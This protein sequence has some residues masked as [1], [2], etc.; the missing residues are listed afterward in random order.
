MSNRARPTWPEGAA[1]GATSRTAPPG[2]DGNGQSTAP[3]DPASNGRP[4]P[5]AN[6]ASGGK[7]PV[8]G[9]KGVAAPGT[10]SAGNG[11]AGNSAAGG[12]SAAG[13][14]GPSRPAQPAG[15][16]G[17]RQPRPATQASPKPNPAPGRPPQQAPARPPGNQAPATPAAGQRPAPVNPAVSQRPEQRGPGPNPVVPGPA[18][19]DQAT[20]AMPAP[21]RAT[22]APAASAAAYGRVDAKSPAPET[23]GD[24]VTA[25][26][27]AVLAKTT[28]GKD[29]DKSG[30]AVTP[31]R[32]DAK[33]DSR[34]AAQSAKSATRPQVRKA[35]LRLSRVDPWS[36]MKTAFL[37]SIAFGIVI[38]VAVFIVWSFIGAAGVFENIN[39]TVSEVLGTPT[40]EPFRLENYINTGKVMGFTTVVACLYVVIITALAT[41]GAF[42]YNLAAT[43][44]GGLELTL[45]SED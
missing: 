34:A 43:L 45:A 30:T 6:G 11:A 17:S 23:I 8:A 29:A 13:S 41:L 2:A 9:G 27:R 44:L 28:G 38:W 18:V 35:R 31:S 12:G 4:G 15:G 1:D 16:Q 3:A 10:G 37:L 20:Q 14:S 33:A 22:P 39:N 42:L 36:V 21:A 5:V 40:A 25:A 19:P 7:A 24:R 26:K 32:I